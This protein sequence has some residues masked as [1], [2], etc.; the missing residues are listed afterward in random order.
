MRKLVRVVVNGLL[1]TTVKSA[2]TPTASSPPS[3]PTD[4]QY[5]LV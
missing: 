1:P 4:R 3:S 2:L 5:W